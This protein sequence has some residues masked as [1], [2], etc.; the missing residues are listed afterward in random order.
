[1]VEIVLPLNAPQEEWQKLR[2]LRLHDNK[3]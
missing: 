3:K 2:L 1:V